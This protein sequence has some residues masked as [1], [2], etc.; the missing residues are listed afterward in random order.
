MKNK[1]IK[2][3][4]K[5]KGVLLDKT[6]ATIMCTMS[7]NLQNSVSFPHIGGNFKYGINMHF[8]L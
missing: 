7:L 4:F 5:G 2:R 3:Q 6:I 8:Q 1:G